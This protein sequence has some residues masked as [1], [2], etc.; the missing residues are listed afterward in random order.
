MWHV[1][2]GVR[3]NQGKCPLPGVVVVVRVGVG[4]AVWSTWR[5]VLDGKPRPLRNGGCSGDTG[6]SGG[7]ACYVEHRMAA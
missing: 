5:N 6:G 1:E 7:G 3:S 2:H 4:C